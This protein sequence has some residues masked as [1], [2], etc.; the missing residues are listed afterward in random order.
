MNEDLTPHL[1][2][3]AASL[4]SEE[5]QNYLIEHGYEL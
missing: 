5:A 1:C 3:K 4:D 2:K